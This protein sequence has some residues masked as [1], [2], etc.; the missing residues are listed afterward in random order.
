MKSYHCLPTVAP[1]LPEVRTISAKY[2]RTQNDKNDSV[3]INELL[4]GRVDS[5]I[6]EE[7]FSTFAGVNHLRQ[8][9]RHLDLVTLVVGSPSTHFALDA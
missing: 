2:D 4:C 6:S 5:I 1:L 3:L 9:V 8:N 7:G